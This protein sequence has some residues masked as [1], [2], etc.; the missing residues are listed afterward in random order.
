MKLFTLPATLLSDLSTTVD[1]LTPAQVA[2]TLPELDPLASNRVVSKLVKKFKEANK[3]FLDECDKTF[4]EK[5]A[6]VERYTKLYQ[7]RGDGME[8][9]DE[10]NLG[11]NL[12]TKMRA[13]TDAVDKASKAMELGKVMV[14]VKLGNDDYA[15]LRKLFP[16]TAAGWVGQNGESF[17][18]AFVTVGDA[19]DDA[20]D[21]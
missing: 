2:Q 16:T 14:D 19:I 9:E 15:H 5:T 8:A 10:K 7:E 20:Q 6:I 12:T 1:K 18:E 13:E 11:S 17:R 21:A 3:I 4:K